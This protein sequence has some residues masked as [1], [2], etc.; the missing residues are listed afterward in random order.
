MTTKTPANDARALTAGALALANE[1][2]EVAALADADEAALA[3]N[4]EA[5]RLAAEFRAIVD[6]AHHRVTGATMPA[7]LA[8]GSTDGAPAARAVGATERA[9]L[10][11]ELG[12][13]LPD[14]PTAELAAMT[15]GELREERDRLRAS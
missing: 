2:I 10:L 11:A 5:Y 13:L 15:V 7:V 1:L 14:R 3:P 8:L 6:R 12:A 9:A 4:A